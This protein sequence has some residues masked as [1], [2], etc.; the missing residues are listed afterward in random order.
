MSKPFLGTFWQNFKK[1]VGTVFP[2]SPKNP[3][4]TSNL[5]LTSIFLTQMSGFRENEAK[6]KKSGRVTILRFL[7]PNFIP[8]FGKIL[9]AV[10][11]I[12]CDARTDGRTHARTHARTDL[13][14]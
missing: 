13:I 10:S 14:L 5:A 3:E 9:G 8:N 1:I 11:E 7:T 4:M 2:R 12:M 6:I